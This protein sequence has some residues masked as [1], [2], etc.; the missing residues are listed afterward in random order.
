MRTT[1]VA[2]ERGGFGSYGAD[3]ILDERLHA[4]LIEINSTPGL[5][6][7]VLCK[8]RSNSFHCNSFGSQC[9]QFDS[10]RAFISQT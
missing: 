1:E 2:F 9:H 7:E 10:S 6:D 8:A 4:W 3:I 5:C